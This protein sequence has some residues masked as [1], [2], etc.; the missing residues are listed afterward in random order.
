MANIYW[1][2]GCYKTPLSGI[3]TW[4]GITLINKMSAQKEQSYP[5]PLLSP[6]PHASMP[7]TIWCSPVYQAS[8]NCVTANFLF[9]LV[10]HRYACI[11]SHISKYLLNA[12]SE[13]LVKDGSRAFLHGPAS[14]EALAYLR[15][16]FTMLQWRAVSTEWFLCQF[17][18]VLNDGNTF[19]CW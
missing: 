9:P 6:P 18:H 7:F 16:Q 13:T 15:G 10:K 17:V 11:R 19:K 4:F 1:N 3:Y 2:S 8:L 5:L 14:R 12:C